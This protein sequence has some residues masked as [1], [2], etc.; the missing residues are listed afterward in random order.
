MASAVA[1][2]GAMAVSIAIYPSV[3]LRS[4]M[5]SATTVSPGRRVRY[6]AVMT[7]DRKSWRVWP[8]PA[9]KTSIGEQRAQCASEGN[10]AG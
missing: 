3:L 10:W 4:P 6:A 2:R 5:A 8:A 9:P 7:G 1:G